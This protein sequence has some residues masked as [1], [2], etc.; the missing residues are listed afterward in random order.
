MYTQ[1]ARA[2]LLECGGYECKEPET[3]KFT[4]AFKRLDAA[5][6]WACRLQLELLALP[7]P[8][9]LLELPSCAPVYAGDPSDPGNPAGGALLARG[10]R[11]RIGAA[12]GFAGSKKPLNTGRADYFGVLPNVAARMMAAAQPGQIFFH[13]CVPPCKARAGVEPPAAAAAAVGGAGGGSGAGGTGAA[14]PPI[15]LGAPAVVAQAR[16]L[17]RAWASSGGGAGEEP[18]QQEQEQQGEEAG[19][20]QLGGLWDRAAAAEGGAGDG[21]DDDEEEAYSPRALPGGRLPTPAEVAAAEAAARAVCAAAERA[22]DRITFTNE[23]LHE[24]K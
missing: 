16:K 14:P 20:P 13:L 11:V 18:Q 5:L 19:A 2:L 17:A 23:D 6:R 8:A 4:L 24:V 15:A 10:L 1:L 7:W 22:G 9:A 12:W 3:G 21:A